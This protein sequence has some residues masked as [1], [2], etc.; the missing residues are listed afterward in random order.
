[1]KVLDGIV[2]FLEYKMFEKE[3]GDVFFKFGEK[4]VFM[5]VF[6]FFIK[7]VYFFLSIFWVE[8]NLEMLIDFV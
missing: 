1:M 8:E 5:N 3:D 4:G 7:I 2:Y 6:I